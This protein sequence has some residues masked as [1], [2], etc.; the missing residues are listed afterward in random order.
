[1]QAAYVLVWTLLFLIKPM[2]DILDWVFNML[3][4][5]PEGQELNDPEEDENGGIPEPQCFESVCEAGTVPCG[6]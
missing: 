1:M 3:L 4:C 2:C 5:S 6:R